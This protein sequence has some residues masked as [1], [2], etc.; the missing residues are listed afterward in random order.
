M[1]IRF[2][3]RRQDED[4]RSYTGLF[5]EAYRL[6]DSEDLESYELTRLENALSWMRANLNIPKCLS[7]QGN[8]RAISWFKPGAKKPL[9][10]AWEIVYLL[11]ERGVPVEM[12]KSSDPGTIIFEDGWQVVA[13]PRRSGR[14]HVSQ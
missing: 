8:E 12:I 11:R 6:R 3:V 5:T 4:S 10:C 2:I 1:Y 13:K 14:L 9:S 7:E